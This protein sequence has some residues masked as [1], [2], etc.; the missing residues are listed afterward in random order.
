MNK[1]I[2]T[3]G[4]LVYGMGFLFLFLKRLFLGPLFIVAGLVIIPV[5]ILLAPEE[6]RKER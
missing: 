4:L 2:F 3:I 5:S 1:K 6:K